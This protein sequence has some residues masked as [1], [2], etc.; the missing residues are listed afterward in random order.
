MTSRRNGVRLLAS[1][2]VALAWA[3]SAGAQILGL[4]YAEEKKG[5]RIYVFNNKANW[6][7]F[8]ASGETG[9]GLTRLGVGPNGETVFADNETALELF[10]FKHGIKEEVVRPRTSTSRLSW[11]N[12][13]TTFDW[14]SG[15]INFGNRL[16]LRF[17]QEIPDGAVRLPGTAAAGDQKGS[18]RIRRYEPQFTGWFYRP[19][20]TAEIEFAFQDLNAAGPGSAGLNTMALNVDWTKGKRLFRTQMGQFKVPFGRQE[21]TSSF[22]QEFVDRSIVAGEFERGRDIGFQIDGVSKNNQLEWRA[23]LFNGNG[24]SNNTNDNSKYQYDARLMWQLG[25]RNVGY[26]EVDFESTDKPLLA[27]AGQFEQNDFDQSVTTTPLPVVASCPCVAGGALKRTM[28]G[29]DL[30]YKYKR[31]FVMGAYYGREID[32]ASPAGTNFKSPGYHAQ[33]GYL[34]DKGRHWEV[35]GRYAAYDPSNQIADNDR[36]EWGIGFNY[37]YNR[38]ALK[39]QSDFR[40]LEDKRANTKNKE[41]RIQTQINF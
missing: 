1:L 39:V 7:R 33:I 18:F 30:V 25:G 10:F 40:Q 20:I 28:W 38:H 2:L 41:L 15:Q 26:S 27:I 31:L 36:T 29:F 9:A 17:T 32:P 3:G 4:F 5:E 8:I 24:R 37:F 6:E 12:G 19:W 22:S 23:G 35:A 11:A 13:R 16:Q 14:D 34:L 21:M